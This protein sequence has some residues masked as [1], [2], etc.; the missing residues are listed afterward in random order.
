MRQLVSRHLENFLTLYEAR[1]M[2]VAAGQKGITQPALSKSLKMLET[3][4][5]TELFLRTP[6]GLDPTPAGELLY[7][8]A[9]SVDQAARMA[10][11][12]VRSLANRTSGRLRVGIGPG[13]AVSSFPHVLVAFQK[14]FPDVLVTAE[15]NVTNALV[16]LLVRDTIDIAVTARPSFGLPDGFGVVPV[17]EI[18]MALVCRKG[19]PLLISPLADSGMIARYGCIAFVE[20]HDV[21]NR[22]EMALGGNVPALRI[23]TQTNSVSLMLKLVSIT[24]HISIVG[25][26]IVPRAREAGLE[27][28]S[29]FQPDW[30]R[31]VDLMCRQAVLRMQPVQALLALWREHLVEES[32]AEKGC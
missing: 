20:D 3:E 14:R 9:R 26:N 27:V 7:R 17:S 29:S 28:L 12:D 5:G 16:E 6:K 25:T 31:E 10:E 23:V 22:T 13:L 21:T 24:D 4:I 1:N 11:L 18:R 19:H 8:H 30:R 15:V 2:H 32:Q